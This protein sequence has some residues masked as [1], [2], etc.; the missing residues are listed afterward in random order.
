MNLHGKQIKPEIIL[1]A[2]PKTI[3]LFCAVERGKA[4]N[5]NGNREQSAK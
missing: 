2:F 5:D 4:S 1:L 3:Y